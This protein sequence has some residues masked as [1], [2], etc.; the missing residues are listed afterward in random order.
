MGK[1]RKDNG[2]G[3]GLM[4]TAH[5]QQATQVSDDCQMLDPLGLTS[6]HY[7]ECHVNNVGRNS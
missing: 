7:A 4:D 2:R 5:D 1:E 3:L 6:L